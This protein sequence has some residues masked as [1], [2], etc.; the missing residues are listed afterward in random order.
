MTG[1]REDP[2]LLCNFLLEIEGLRVAG[3]TEV[4]G[5]DAQIEFVEYREGG[6]NGYTHRFPGPCKYPNAL[7]LRKGLTSNLELWEWF[8][9]T[10]RGIITKKSGSVILRDLDGA[11]R[12]RWNFLNALPAKWSGPALKADSSE[13]AVQSI[14]LVHQGLVF[15]ATG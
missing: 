6:G 8:H 3:F 9:L 4:N 2:Y 14:E 13:I 15:D 5:L 1:K 7:V 11:E 12:M 10:S